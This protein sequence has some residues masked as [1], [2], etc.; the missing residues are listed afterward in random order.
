[1]LKAS[2]KAS[3]SASGH[4]VKL[5]NA[6]ECFFEICLFT[7]KLVQRDPSRR[8]AGWQD[9]RMFRIINKPANIPVADL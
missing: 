4:A 5:I 6:S 3:L 9:G 2:R 1:M 8:M 7:K